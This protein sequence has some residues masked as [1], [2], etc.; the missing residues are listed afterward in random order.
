MRDEQRRTADNCT[1]SSSSTT[2][3]CW[4]ALK[5]W[6]PR[7]ENKSVFMHS[8]FLYL[9]IDI[10]CRFLITFWLAHRILEVSRGFGG[11][12][13]HSGRVYPSSL[14]ADELVC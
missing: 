11:E 4:R 13:N 5:K 9:F 10:S 3:K 12:R 14:I 6:E 2:P 8:S 1:T 7:P